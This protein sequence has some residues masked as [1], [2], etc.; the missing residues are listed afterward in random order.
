[1]KKLYKSI[2]NSVFA[3]L[4][5]FQASSCNLCYACSCRDLDILLLGGH[6]TSISSKEYQQKIQT[7][8][9]FYA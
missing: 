6:S 9:E 1:M 4:M 3:C 7:Y 2:A 8:M 5:I